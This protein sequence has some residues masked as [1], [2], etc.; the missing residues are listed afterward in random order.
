MNFMNLPEKYRKNA[1]FQILPIEY[2]NNPTYGKGA[3]KGPKEIIK[4]SK[5]LEYYDEQFDNEPFAKGIKTIKNKKEV[6]SKFTIS[7]G[8]DHS[9][10]IGV[11]KDLEKKYKDFSVIIL[12][13][14]PDMFHSWNNSQYNHRCVSQRISEN[15]NILQIGIRSMDIDEKE[16]IDSKKNINIIKAYDFNK[17]KLKQELKKLKNKVYIS[18]D[19]DVFDISFI[20]NT[21]TPEPGGFS[22]NQ[23]IEI[24]E[25]IFKN[26]EVIGADINEFAPRYNFKAEAFSLAKLAYKI[27]ALKI[28]NK[29]LIK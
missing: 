5:H 21:G 23:V 25:E 27:M 7:L 8:G 20:R 13:A 1:F 18:I 10:T 6:N 26:K 2:E 9:I 11:V 19:V 22:W 24:L 15:H 17:E 3:K 14:H 29:N 4:A 16:I 12:D 28:L